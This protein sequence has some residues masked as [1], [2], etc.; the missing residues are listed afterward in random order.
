MTDNRQTL[1][2]WSS[3]IRRGLL[4]LCILNL[5]EDDTSYGYEI[6]TRLGAQPAL[7]V[8]EGTVYP[9]LRRLKTLGHVTTFWQE[10]ASGPPRQYYKL[11]RRGRKH[12]AKL[13]EEWR[14]ICKAVDTLG[15]SSIPGDQHG[16]TG[17]AAENAG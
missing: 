17:R 1:D 15:S 2:S 16:Q 11:S 12:L 9:L 10:S 14:E 8:G 13:R 7:A 6:V 4:E 3:Q 5:L